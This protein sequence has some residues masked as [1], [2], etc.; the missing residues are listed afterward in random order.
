MLRIQEI[1]IITMKKRHFTVHLKCCESE[2]PVNYVCKLVA[3]NIDPPTDV[4]DGPSPN[5]VS[6][7]DAYLSFLSRFRS[8]LEKLDSSD[9]IAEVDNPCN[10]ELISPDDQRR[11]L[12][13]GVVV[14]V[15]G[16]ID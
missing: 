10:T 11:I 15:N 13:K 16:N 5:S 14:L 9:A 1:E 3:T 8:A 6:A 12:G 4:I 7:E 2:N